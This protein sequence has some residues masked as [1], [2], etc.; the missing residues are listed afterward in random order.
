VRRGS[1]QRL[2]TSTEGSFSA[3][4]EDSPFLITSYGIDRQSVT[5]SRFLLD[6]QQMRKYT[7]RL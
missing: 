7:S 3:R 2:L 6:R 5:P 1:R 4:L